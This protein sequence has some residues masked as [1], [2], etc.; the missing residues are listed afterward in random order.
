MNSSESSVEDELYKP[1]PDSLQ[2]M[3]K[4][5]AIKEKHE[6]NLRIDWHE[7][8]QLP[9]KFKT[10]RLVFLEMLK[11][12]EIFCDGHLRRIGVPKPRIDRLNDKV[13]LVHS[14]SY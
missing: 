9:A 10:H 12:L 14:A 7:D 1:T 8:I 6:E 3:T 2:Q 13:S 11:E 4:N 5:K